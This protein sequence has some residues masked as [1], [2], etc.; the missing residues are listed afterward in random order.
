MSLCTLVAL[1][2]AFTRC[3]VQTLGVSFDTVEANKT[4]ADTTG[5]RFPLFCDTDYIYVGYAP[6]SVTLSQ[7]KRV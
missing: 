2:D 4:F 6:P 1:Y 5:F 7:G 3:N